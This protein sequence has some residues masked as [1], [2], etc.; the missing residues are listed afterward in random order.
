[1]PPVIIARM[2]EA[3]SFPDDLPPIDATRL[4]RALTEALALS[5]DA[6]CEAAVAADG[7]AHADVVHDATCA[8]SRW[9]IEVR[10]RVD[11]TNA[12]LMAAPFAAQPV[13]VRLLVA[14]Q[15]TA[16]RGR[17][18]RIWRNPPQA[19]LTFSVTFERAPA[20]APPTGWSLI[21]GAAVARALREQVP[22]VQVKWP[23]DLQ[24]GRRKCGGIL[25]ETRRQQ[26][27]DGRTIER[28]VTG[29]GLNLLPDADRDASAGQPSVA[30]FE[31]QPRSD[32]DAL[33]PLSREQLLANIV[34]ELHRRWQLMLS[35]G[36]GA[37]LA[38]WPDVDALAGADVVV[39][40]GGRPLLEGRA[41][42]IDAGG[43][44]R[45]RSGLDVHRIVV[46]EVSVR[47][48]G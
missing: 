24:R 15:Q 46:G 6:Q 36:A 34:G 20:G 47:R 44:L 26:A 16:G 3:G 43:E 28:L 33:L 45:V 8:P 14:R 4:R 1:M 19:S 40:D 35:D 21:A 41:E 10:D 9:V 42:G 11:S 39:L 12:V 27:P 23:N 30:L 2:S 31:G 38:D 5:A 25:V 48:A 32:A 7:D 18:G 37:A 29:I 22:D 13:P 17:L